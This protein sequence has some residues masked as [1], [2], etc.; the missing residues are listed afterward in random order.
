MVYAAGGQSGMSYFVG[1]GEDTLVIA[2]DICHPSLF[3]E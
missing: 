2:V 3:D 1:Q